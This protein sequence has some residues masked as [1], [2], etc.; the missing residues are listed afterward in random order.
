[1]VCSRL[2]LPTWLAELNHREMK[3]SPSTSSNDLLSSDSRF[4]YF[5]FLR[6]S[7]KLPF[8]T[9]CACMGN[10]P[11]SATKSSNP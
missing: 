4:V 11:S 6:P 8:F 5:Q 10:M 7:S 1:M 3:S 9:Y 2:K